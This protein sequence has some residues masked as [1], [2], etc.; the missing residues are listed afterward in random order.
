MKLLAGILPA[1]VFTASAL[2]QSQ[3]DFLPRIDSPAG[4]DALFGVWG[5][6]KQCRAYRAGNESNP[7]RL[8]YVID[9]EWLRQ[10]FIYCYLFWQG[11]EVADGV[12][13]ARA[14][15]RCGEDDMRDYRLQFRLQDR[16]LSIGWSP[17]FA[18][19]GLQACRS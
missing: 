11:H 8:P 1:L 12:T 10:G 19:F 17:D 7:A 18:T 13:L 6:E 3:Y 4:P 9:N 14:V 16:R 5:D 2:A 15:A